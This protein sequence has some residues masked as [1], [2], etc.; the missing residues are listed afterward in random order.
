VYGADGKIK[1]KKV[2]MADG[3]FRDGTPQS[4]YFPVGHERAGVFKGMAVILEERGHGDA[5][6]I[7]A[8]CPKFECEKGA[9]QCCC[10]RM[11]YNKPDFVE[12]ESLLEAA[13]KARGFRAIFFPKF[14]CEL[15]FIE[16]CWGYSKR[17]YRQFPPSTKEANLEHNVR[18]ALKS[19]PLVSVRQLVKDLLILFRPVLISSCQQLLNS[20]TQVHGWIPKGVEWQTGCLGIK[21]VSW[22]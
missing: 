13:C 14:H 1:K 18:E 3:K 16:Q 20:F 8:E 5:S 10:R 7:R 21:E 11:L 2:P 9:H 6:K 17:I 22:A 19:I 4:F 15:N 12:V